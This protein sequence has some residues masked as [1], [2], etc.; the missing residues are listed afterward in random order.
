G[1]VRVKL[2]EDCMKRSFIN[3]RRR[4]GQ[5]AARRKRPCTNHTRLLGDGYVA[6]AITCSWTRLRDCSFSR[7]SRPFFTLT[8]S[9]GKT[10][11][12]GRL[13]WEYHA[14]SMP[15]SAK[16]CHQIWG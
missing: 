15:R 13:R 7:N 3:R 6:W 5:A 9:Q 16:V 14:G 4:G 2:T 1:V 12:I 8:W 10:S 11:S